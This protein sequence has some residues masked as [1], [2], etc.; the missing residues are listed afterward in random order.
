MYFYLE[1][2]SFSFISLLCTYW[3]KNEREVNLPVID[4]KQSQMVK[5]PTDAIKR[6]ITTIKQFEPKGRLKI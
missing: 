3:K 2:L 6:E 5:N 4:A 1:I